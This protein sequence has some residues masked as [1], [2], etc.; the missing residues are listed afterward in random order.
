MSVQSTTNCQPASSG[1]AVNLQISS[2]TGSESMPRVNGELI[3][4][5]PW[6]SRAFGMAVSLSQQ[7]LFTWATFRGEL[8]S[9]IKRNNQNG[10]DEYYLCW[11]EALEMCLT[12]TK[13]LDAEAIHQREHEFEHH[14]R[15]EVF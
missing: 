9:S 11:L 12:R 7:G 8:A 2:M 13:V 3:F 4:E 5:A 15:D 14:E 6:Q 10:L 1:D